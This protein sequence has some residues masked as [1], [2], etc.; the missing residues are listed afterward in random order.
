[1]APA[2]SIDDLRIVAH[3][4]SGAPI[5]ADVMAGHESRRLTECAV[6]YG[7]GAVVFLALERAQLLD[8]LDA[9]S[10]AT[11]RDELITTTGANLRR[12][13]QLS[14]ILTTL[15]AAA[16]TS[17]AYKGPALSWQAYGH[18]GGRLFDDLDILVVPADRTA[19]AQALMKVGYTR[20]L[21]EARLGAILPRVAHVDRLLPPSA[22]LLPV[23]IH[24]SVASWRVA[25]KL[26]AA[27]LLSRR[28]PCPLP[29]G[30][31]PTLSTEDTLIT[32]SVHG[33]THTWSHV[34]FVCEIAGIIR[35]EP[36][37]WDI[38]LNR[39]AAAH[40]AREV[41]VGVL[42]AVDLCG[43]PVPAEVLAWARRD[44]VAH[45]ITADRLAALCETRPAPERWQGIREHLRYRERLVD[46]G[47]YFARNEIIGWALK[48][49]WERWRRY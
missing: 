23:E 26:P 36:V 45:L 3:V 42:M 32:L 28:V 37:Q 31:I 18:I 43:A 8:T 21:H 40:V 5:S 48:L 10:L 24:S 20:E 14:S 16:I 12:A 27:A 41:R 25:A 35:R 2:F 22:D 44:R 47:R 15:D 29:T 49:P 19:A 1:M 46:K 17:L 13:S 34:R 33:C 4:S 39:A 38:L 7:M 30:E 9:T 11:L 6:A